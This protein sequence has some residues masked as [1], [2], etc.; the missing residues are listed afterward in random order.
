MDPPAMAH[1][2][3]R[4]GIYEARQVHL[5]SRRGHQEPGSRPPAREAP[6]R[7]KPPMKREDMSSE[8]ECEYVTRD[9]N[10]VL[11]SNGIVTKVMHKFDQQ[12]NEVI[13]LRNA[14]RASH[15]APMGV[16]LPSSSIVFS[17]ISIDLPTRVKW[18][19]K[20]SCGAP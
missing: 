7:T 9:G 1:E 2:G 13:D 3:A 18:R 14:F 4:A 20:F 8:A 10:F 16:L 17:R 5:L 19:T 12:G 6:L 11:W 15:P